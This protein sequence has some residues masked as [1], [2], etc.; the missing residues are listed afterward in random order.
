[1]KK[2]TFIIAETFLS[3]VLVASIAAVAVIAIDLKTDGG[4]IPPEFYGGKSQSSTVQETS[5]KSAAKDNDKEM[6]KA[7]SSAEASE[8]SEPSQTEESSQTTSEPSA[9]NT[10]GLILTQPKDLNDQPKE[11]TGFI[12]DFGYGY[13][14]LGFNHLIVVDSDENS[15]AKVYCYQKGGNDYWWNIAGEGKAITDKGF[16]GEKGPDFD[17]KP[18]SKKSPLGFYSLGEGFYIGDKPDT[19]Y[20]IFEITEDTYWVTDPNSAFYNTK[21]EGTDQKDWSDAEHMISSKDTYKYGI[22]IN[23]NTYNIDSQLAGAIFLCCGDKPTKGSVA[24]PEETM[25]NILEWL[26]EDSNTYIYIMT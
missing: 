22:V 18:D 14:N 23:Y 12:N 25:K 10:S 13:E 9:Q 8:K 19:T 1:M 16:V 3:L 17:I 2:P 6:S 11:L 5:E 21:A 7:E 24:V 15:G 20:P 4:I 26:Q